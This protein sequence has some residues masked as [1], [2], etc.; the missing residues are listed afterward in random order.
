MLNAVLLW[1]FLSV[2]CGIVPPKPDFCGLEPGENGLVRSAHCI[3]TDPNKEETDKNVD[4]MIG[5]TC[6]SPKDVGDVKTFIKQ[7][8]ISLDKT[9]VQRISS[10]KTSVD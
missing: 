1:V 2:S 5:Y 9:T 4:D 7:L 6:F 8:L 10:G 3:P